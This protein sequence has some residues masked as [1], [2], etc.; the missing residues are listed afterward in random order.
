MNYSLI[1]ISKN[2]KLLSVLLESVILSM[3]ISITASCIFLSGVIGIGRDYGNYEDIINDI[4]HSGFSLENN[5]NFDIG[6][7][8]IIF[9]LTQLLFSAKLIYAFLIFISLFLKFL[10][11]SFLGLYNKKYSNVSLT[12]L[13]IIGGL[14]L[15][16]SRFFPLHEFT[17]IRVAISI[18][19]FYY[20]FII[21]ESDTKIK[22]EIF[23]FINNRLLNIIGIS[24][25]ILCVLFH[26]IALVHLP[27]TFLTVFC[28]SRKKIIL[29]NA[30]IFLF[31][32]I[33]FPIIINNDFSPISYSAISRIGSYLQESSDSSSLKI[34]HVLDFVFIII[35]FYLVDFK[36]PLQRA[37]FSMYTFSLTISLAIT[38]G[39]PYLLVFSVRLSE[40]I[41]TFCVPLIITMSGH[42]KYLLIW[43]WIIACSIYYLSAYQASNYFL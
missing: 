42:R 23:G 19:F 6:F 36:S 40:Y 3:I 18:A 20:A 15:Y 41:Q 26:T 1:S 10:I 31:F 4:L 34:Y 30:L 8:F 9:L 37:L 17:Q 24:C 14:I 12:H 38:I 21:I 2:K 22:Q 39:L 25:A 35:C 5:Y 28:N 7:V 32:W 27:L 13:G 16:S 29:V 43:P 33:A 11:F